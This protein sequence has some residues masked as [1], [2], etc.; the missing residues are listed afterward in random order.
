MY[1]SSARLDMAWHTIRSH[2]IA[3]SIR[4]PINFDMVISLASVSNA[5]DHNSKPNDHHNLMRF[6]ITVAFAGASWPSRGFIFLII[7]FSSNAISISFSLHFLSI[8]FNGSLSPFF[9]FPTK[10]CRFIRC[11]HGRWRLKC[12]NCVQLMMRLYNLIIIFSTNAWYA[13]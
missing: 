1:H 6:G 8:V 5:N 11:Y 12:I 13:K 4:C 2:R 9:L 10:L 3:F 7:M